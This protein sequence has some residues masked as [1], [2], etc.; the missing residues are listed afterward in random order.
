[1]GLLM[2]AGGL[3]CRRGGANASN[4]MLSENFTQRPY[5]R[6]AIIELAT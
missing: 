3:A 1:M 6:R 4:S 5:T 2:T